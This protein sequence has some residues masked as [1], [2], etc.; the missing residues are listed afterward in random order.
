MAEDRL[1]WSTKRCQGATN[2]RLPI[3]LRSA[4]RTLGRRRCGHCCECSA[5][6]EL[7]A[8][9]NDPDSGERDGVGWGRGDNGRSA[10]GKREPRQWTTDIRSGRWATLSLGRADSRAAQRSDAGLDQQTRRAGRWGAESPD[11]LPVLGCCRRGVALLE[12]PVGR[13]QDAINQ[14]A[15]EPAEALGTCS[16]TDNAPAT[17]TLFQDGDG[18]IQTVLVLRGSGCRELVA[19]GRVVVA[20][21][22]ATGL[23]W[24]G[25]EPSEPS[26]APRRESMFRAHSV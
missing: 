4:T 16:G 3:G 9:H 6:A 21:G 13:A 10:S 23:P 24:T 25:T 15:T 20:G 2:A 14:Q 11:H 17:L 7:L 19:H 8:A 12:H 5:R 22:S 18:R 26:F 1:R